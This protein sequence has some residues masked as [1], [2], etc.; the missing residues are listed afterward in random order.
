[1]SETRDRLLDAISA[2]MAG[3]ADLAHLSN[4]STRTY[5]SNEYALLLIALNAHEQNVAA[6]ALETSRSPCCNAAIRCGR[7]GNDLARERSVGPESAE[8][9]A[10]AAGVEAA[11]EHWRIDTASG[12]DIDALCARAAEKRG[13]Q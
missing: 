9:R 5:L 3:T 6:R 8:A 4:A 11:I 12:D 13:R 2:W 7:C 1:M 10:F